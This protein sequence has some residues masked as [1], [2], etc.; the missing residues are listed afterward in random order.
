[1]GV[2]AASALLGPLG[3]MWHASLVP[4]TYSVME[5]GHAEF[6]GGPGGA[7]AAHQH[8]HQHD[9]GSVAH[10]GGSQPVDLVSLAGPRGRPADVRETLVAREEQIRVASEHT[11]EGYTLNH[12]SPGPEIRAKRGQLV[13]VRLVNESVSDGVTLHWHGVHVPN[14]EDGVAGVTQDAVQVGQ[15]YV[16]RFVADQTGTFWYHSHQDSHEQVPKGLFGALVVTP[17]EPSGPSDAVDVLAQV[18]TYDGRRTVNG[19]VGASRVPA[20]PGA[21]A[22][23]RVINTDNGLMRTWVSG[24]PYRVVAVDGVDL[25]APEPVR[26]TAFALP[27][28][29]RVDLELSVPTDGSAARVGLG[30]ATAL[31]LGP[32]DASAP[33]GAE[34]SAS[35][36]LLDYGSPAAVAFDP[37]EADRRFTYDIGRRPGFLDGR[38]G[39]WWTINGH[40]FPDLPMYVVSEHDVVRVRLENSSG[41]AHPMHL[42]GHHALV[43]SRN[44]RPVTGSPWW[45]DS[46]DIDDGDSYELAFVADNPGIWMFHCHD[47]PHAVE[48]LVTHLAYEDV[49]EP[50]VVGGPAGNRP[51]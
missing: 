37:D 32:E 43:L 2:V 22:R 21:R 20:E 12:D 7:T 16:Y 17:A 34:P 47:L 39:L 24:A 1:M 31:L 25:N 27:A 45:T 33:P 19:R 10:V 30:G 3:W 46:L 29:G 40:T 41:E 11:V 14:A 4:D 36:D 38:P 18:H 50:F 8:D 35:V 13:E 26:D 51:E 5:M 48:G 44:G 23:V 42:H 49:A 6:G 15:D 9:H 28:G